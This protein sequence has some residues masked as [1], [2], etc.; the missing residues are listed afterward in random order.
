MRELGCPGCTILH[1][2]IP[3][4]G[5]LHFANIS[6]KPNHFKAGQVS[7]LQKYKGLINIV[8]HFK[9]DRRNKRKI[10]CQAEVDAAA[11]HARRFVMK[12]WPAKEDMLYSPDG[13]TVP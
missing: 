1:P 4:D 10:A 13:A 5:E 3:P 9:E 6:N 8:N 2:D 7:F 12:L 11:D